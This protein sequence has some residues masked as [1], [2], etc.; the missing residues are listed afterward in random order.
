MPFGL[1]PFKAQTW[2]RLF[3]VK[4]IVSQQHLGRLG[5]QLDILNTQQGQMLERLGGLLGSASPANRRGSGLADHNLWQGRLR[6]QDDSPG[7][8]LVFDVIN[9]EAHRAPPPPSGVTPLDMEAESKQRRLSFLETQGLSPDEALATEFSERQD[10][11]AALR[12]E[13][14]I[15]AELG[16]GLFQGLTTPVTDTIPGLGP[17][18]ERG[19]ER[20]SGL[21]VV[22]PEL[23]LASRYALSPLG[24]ATGALAPGMTAAG[25]AGQTALGSAGGGLEEAGVP[26]AERPFGLPLDIGPRGAG[27]VIGGL[28]T[29]GMLTR[30]GQALL[31]GTILE[32][33]EEAFALGRAGRE[34]A[35]EAFAPPPRAPTA[36]GGKPPLPER[37]YGGAEELLRTKEQTLLRP[38][39]A[40]RVPGVKQLASGL[41]P[42]V[43]TDR[44]V[45]GAYNA[46]QAAQ[47]SLETEF[48]AQRL[49]PLDELK[50]LFRE[51]PP[52]Y[53][54]PEDHPFKG[55]LK[56]WG[57]NPEFYLLSPQHRAAAAAYDAVNDATVARVRGEFGGDI[58]RFPVKDGGFYTATIATRESVDEAAAKVAESYTS[59][60]LSRGARAKRRV[61]EGAYQRWLRNP[62][63]RAETDIDVLTGVHD[64]ALAAMA[65]RETFKLGSGGRTR[66][67]LMEEIHPKLYDRM[68]GLR[69]RVQGLQG[70]LRRLNLKQADTVDAFLANP[71]ETTLSDLADALDVTVSRGQRVGMNAKAVNAEIKATRQEIR[72]L[73][74][75]WEAANLEPYV[76]NR[77]TFLHHLPEQSQ[78]IDSLLQTKLNIGQGLADAIDE[79]RLT[80]FAGDVS[81]LTIQGLLGGLSHPLT[82]ARDAPN[83]LKALVNPDTL[84]DIAAREPDEVRRFTIATGRSFGEVGP[85]FVQTAKG[86]ERPR[87]PFTQLR[88]GKALNDRLMAATEEIRYAAWKGDTN[89]LQRLNPGMAQEVADSESAN[90]LSKL[91]PALNPA[92]TGRSVLRA[93]FERIPVISTSF[94][95]GPVGLLKDATSALAKL[96]FSKAL[97]PAARWQALSGREQLA[98]LRSLNLAGS[99]SALTVG[100]YV[101]SGFSPEEAVKRALDPTG[102]NPRFLS[103]ALGKDRYIPVGG[104]VRSFIRALVPTKAGTVKGVP[105]YTPFTGL[106][107]WMRAKVTPGIKTPIDLAR[108]R[109]FFGGKI[110]T[111]SF[112]ENVL[113]AVW[114][115]ANSVLPLAVAGPSEAVR[116]GEVALT[117]VSEL[118]IRGGGQ[119]AGSDIRELSLSEAFERETGRSWDETPRALRDQLVRES[120]FLTN[121]AER[122]ESLF[123]S[124][125]KRIR[126]ERS[127]ALTPH[128]EDLLGQPS[129]EAARAY[130]DNRSRIMSEFGGAAG[131]AFKDL[132]IKPKGRDQELLQQFYEVDFAAD[133]N[134]NGIRGDDEDVRLALDKQDGIR[135]DMSGALRSALDNPENFFSDQPVIDVERRRNEAKD[136]IREILAF[137]KWEGLSVEQGD[138]LDDVVRRITADVQRYKAQAVREGGD[139]DAVTFESTAEWL[140]GNET[141]REA[142]AE[143]AIAVS[144]G[145]AVRG[146]DRINEA[147]K[148]KDVLLFI[149]P[150]FFASVLPVE[151]ERTALSED[152]INQLLPVGVGQ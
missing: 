28:A 77:S 22:G 135:K 114:Y 89:L 74:P 136:A 100:T 145:Q 10:V 138:E 57:D 133:Y 139:P 81:P 101:A 75:A 38:G 86:L 130:N 82:T 44:P 8:G 12:A 71:E 42:S 120:S 95:G 94:I 47:A 88:P 84:L 63:F 73:R 83:I 32:P 70:T 129:I 106:Q 53:I 51:N 111:G 3:Q 143:N 1:N 29:P 54:G 126:T 11:L 93:R 37:G 118:A 50:A 31:R 9:P 13:P 46:Q 7:K 65:G 40:T 127:T 122:K 21:P 17:A 62:T 112:P 58:N 35:E 27:E 97:S 103:I 45:L 132:N 66:L 87:I 80:A 141:I 149:F 15:A 121:L 68:T 98:L 49:S 117:D 147:L 52:R 60:T 79:V 85:E 55:T 96:G 108:N 48:A 131:E 59:S 5:Q 142:D 20:V 116:R 64:H 91:I 113:R 140:A 26:V 110:A 19:I 144:S 137:P 99:L 151:A 102:N 4:N 56:D 23:G 30:P 34:G 78:A 36:T 148:W 41:N 76:R 69:Q 115:G 18:V 105:I 128:A 92:E 125:G 104:P 16:A 134:E 39:A 25:L 6:G 43:S 33:P 119:F 72:S 67:E 146:G 2:E 123:P 109:D 90:L 24:I 61:Y 150:D 124:E 14:N 107:K 152:E